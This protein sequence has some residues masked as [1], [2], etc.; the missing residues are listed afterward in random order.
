MQKLSFLA[1]VLLMT[2]SVACGDDTSSGGDADGGGSDLGEGDTSEDDQGRDL[3]EDATED[4]TTEDTLVDQHHRDPDLTVDTSDGDATVEDSHEGDLADSGDTNADL[5]D[6]DVTDGGDLPDA[7]PDADGDVT[8]GGDGDV[9]EAPEVTDVFPPA[10]AHTGSLV[11][12]GTGFGE[13]SSVKIGEE[14]MDTVTVNSST[15]IVVTGVPLSLAVGHQDLVVSTG[16]SNSEPHDV[17]VIHLVINEFDPDTAGA[18]TEFIEV[19]V[20]LGEALSLQGYVLVHFNGGETGDPLTEGRV[21]WHRELGDG[22]AMT[23]SDG[24]LVLSEALQ[25]GEDALA[26]YQ[27]DDG[28]F[29]GTPPVGDIGAEGLIDAVVWESGPDDDSED[30]QSLMDTEDADPVVNE[31]DTNEEREA[32]SLQRCGDGLLD[33][34]VWTTAAPTAG[35]E[36]PCD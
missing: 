8:D 23:T 17:T 2:I 29:S 35:D 26:I 10:L 11:I 14:T 36:N 6:G 25:N 32:V 30:L 12:T 4:P 1:L 15:E 22:E 21:I 34:Q 33:Y 28:D 27:R 20:G 31:G 3:T 9:L 7:V 5:A 13:D 19:G 16:D 24:F 18:E